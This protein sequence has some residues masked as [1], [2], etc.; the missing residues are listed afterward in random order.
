MHVTVC[1]VVPYS[2]GVPTLVNPANAGR[3]AVE[4]DHAQNGVGTLIGEGK[5]GSDPF[6]RDPAVSV[7]IGHP[8][9]AHIGLA[10]ER[11]RHSNGPGAAHVASVD[12]DLLDP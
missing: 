1:A 5:L 10:G 3:T 6:G 11:T 2:G 4:A 7:G 12:R 8:D 9:T